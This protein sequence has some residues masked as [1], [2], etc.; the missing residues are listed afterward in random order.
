MNKTKLVE[1]LEITGG[2]ILLTLGFY[3]FL[4][5]QNLVIGG[6][7]GISVLVQNVIPVS[8]FILVANIFLLFIGLIF[9]GKA[10][11]LKTVYAT[12]LYPVIVFVL[13]K[14]IPA[15]FFMQYI[16]ESPYLVA[17]VI[18]SLICRFWTRTCD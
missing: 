13:E 10:F 2:V 17:G 11:F 8:I 1:L 7:M 6:V 15:N 3:F 18:W 4:L 14:T 9:L 12:I 16:E 5:P